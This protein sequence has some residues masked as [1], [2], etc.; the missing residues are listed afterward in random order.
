M[1]GFVRFCSENFARTN[2]KSPNS[3]VQERN[4]L[5]NKNTLTWRQTKPNIII[6][7]HE[8]I[9]LSNYSRTGCK[10]CGNGEPQRRLIIGDFPTIVWKIIWWHLIKL[11]V[12]SNYLKELETGIGQCIRSL[13]DKTSIFASEPTSCYQ[14]C[15]FTKK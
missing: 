7:F 3:F 10:V 8:I 9:F 11:K 1:R 12:I 2:L 13:T 6:I 14:W 15:Q 4:L 5:R